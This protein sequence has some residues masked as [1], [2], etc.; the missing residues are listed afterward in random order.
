M[1]EDVI[2]CQYMGLNFTLWLENKSIAWLLI[3]II[4]PKILSTFLKPNK[5]ILVM[6]L[7]CLNLVIARQNRDYDMRSTYRFYQMELCDVNNLRSYLTKNTSWETREYSHIVG[8][9]KQ[10][11]LK[12]YF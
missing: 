11:R 2:A 10:V 1:N 7:V 12:T 8:Y 5:H 3:F 9:I 4:N 6:I